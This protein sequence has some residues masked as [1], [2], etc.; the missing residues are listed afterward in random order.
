MGTQSAAFAG[1]LDAVFEAASNYFAM[2]AEPMRLRILHAICDR[3]RTVNDI[4]AE[5]GATQTTIS[6]HLNAM[7]RAGALTRRRDR[8]FTWYGV[9]DSTLTE[10]CRTVCVHVASRDL[11]SPGIAKANQ[12]NDAPSRQEKTS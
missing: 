9:A 2:L 8:N 3:E 12:V 5:T 4:V 6:R 7:Y 10:L 11:F 1:D